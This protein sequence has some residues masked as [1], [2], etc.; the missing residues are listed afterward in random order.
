[1]DLNLDLHEKAPLADEPIIETTL[2]PQGFEDYVGQSKV[3][4]NLKM[5]IEAAN[6]RRS[7]RVQPVDAEALA[8]QQRIADAF[9][10]AQVLPRKVVVADSPVWKPAKLG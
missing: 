2:R 7:Y 1:M 9:T 3:T 8:E 6:Q 10:Q 4:S 5:F